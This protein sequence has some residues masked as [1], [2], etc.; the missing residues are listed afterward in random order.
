MWNLVY[1]K[2]HFQI[3]GQIMGYSITDIKT[4][5]YPLTMFPQK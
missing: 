5:G 2:D 1:E 3:G 4:T